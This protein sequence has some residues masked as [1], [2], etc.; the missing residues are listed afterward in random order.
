MNAFDPDELNRRP[1]KRYNPHTGCPIDPKTGRDYPIDE[2]TFRP[3]DPRSK[4]EMPGLFDPVTKQ[5][6]NHDTKEP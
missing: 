3:Y 6:L 1:G 5:A 4:E 2:T